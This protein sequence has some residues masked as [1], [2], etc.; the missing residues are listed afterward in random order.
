MQGRDVASFTPGQLPS[1]M[2]L[3][4]N[5][6]VGSTGRLLVTALYKAQA[7]MAAQEDLNNLLH[8]LTICAQLFIVFLFKSWYKCVPKTMSIRLSIALLLEAI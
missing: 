3:S 1:Q 5:K 8:N 7:H 6:T 2:T 4:P